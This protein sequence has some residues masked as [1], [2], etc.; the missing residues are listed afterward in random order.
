MKRSK[1]DLSSVTNYNTKH[2]TFGLL[3]SGDV[4]AIAT[5]QIL[6]SDKLAAKVLR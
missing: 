1:F 5:V 2:P 3:T 4:T 6:L